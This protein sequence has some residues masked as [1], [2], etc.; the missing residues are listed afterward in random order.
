[1]KKEVK[2][3]NRKDRCHWKEIICRLK[4]PI[5]FNLTETA[6]LYPLDRGISRADR[7]PEHCDKGEKLLQTGTES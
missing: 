5:A 3:R 7:S 6:P 1:M 4:N 2:D